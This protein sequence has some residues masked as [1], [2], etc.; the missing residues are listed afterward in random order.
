MKNVL[1]FV[2]LCSLLV[3][4]RGA[5]A[6]TFE[7][8]GQNA[9]AQK[10]QAK[11]GKA[12]KGK[13]VE[14]NA[15]S[16]GI[17]WGSS[18]EVGRMA[19]AAQDA[20]KHNN[21]VQAASFAERAANAAPQDA[22][23]WFLLGYTSRLAGRNQQSL[24]AY[25]RGLKIAPNSVDGLSGMAQTYAKMGQIDQAKRLLLQI[26][27][28]NPRRQNDLLM[29]GE[30][31]L[32][33][34]DTQQGITL[35]QRAEAIK[36]TSH[37]ELM[38]AVA[39]LK[40]KQPAKAK[41]L[42]DLAKRRDPKNPA[43]FRAV[44][45]YYREEHDYKNAIAI[46][47]SAPNPSPEI[48]ADLGYTYGLNGD[49][50]ESADAYIRAANAE[51]KQIGYQLSASQALMT[52]GQMD[53]SRQFI[54]RAEAIDANNYRLHAIKAGL[55]KIE[56]RPQDAI[57]EYTEAI[58]RLPQG[59]V[60]EGDLY[61]IQLRLNL[62]DLYREQGDE[63]ASRQQINVAEQMVNKLN[64]QGPA[65][66]EF[67][68]VRAGIF[69]AEQNYTAAEADLKEAL[70]L[71]PNNDNISLQ[72][73]NLLWRTKRPAEARKI[74]DTIL[75]KDKNNRFALEALGY[76]ARETGDN[77][78]AEAFFQ[79]LAKAYPNDYVAYLALGDLYTSTREFPR[80]NASYESAFTI[81]PTNP[82]IIANAANAAIEARQIDL[83][84]AWV[85]RAQGKLKDDPRIMRED[86]RYLFH[87][88]KFLESAQLGYKVLQQLPK[89]R[90]A[91]VYLV[92]ALYNLGRYDDVLSVAEKYE[93]ILEREPNFPLLVGHVHKQVNLLDQAV[94]DYS[95][96]IARDPKMAE[97][98]VNR[99]YVENDLQD[100][101]ASTSDFQQ[102]LTL[103]P[104]NGIAHLGMSFAN[105]QLRHGKQAL[106][107]ADAAE[108]LM[109]ESGATHLA[110][111]TAYRQMRL[112]DKAE[113]E[114]ETALKYAPDDLKLN[115][116]LADTQ[117]HA[118]HYPQALQTLD[119]ALRLSPDDPLIYAQ[120]AHAHAAMHD[121]EKT[122]QYV[123]A[124]ERAGNSEAAILLDTGDALLML[125][126]RQ[127]AMERFARALQAPDADK[128]ATRLMIAKVFVREGKFD[129]AKQQVAL[130]LAESRVGEA[131][132]VTADNLIEAANIFLAM[133]DYDL[134][135]GYF[136]RAKNAGAA[137]EVVAIGM[138]NAY[139]A[140]GK[141]DEAQAQ[142]ASLGN[143][144]DF[145]KNYDYMLA[146]GTFYH[147]RHDTRRAL[148][149]FARAYQVAGDD[150]IAEKQMEEVATEEGMPITRKVSVGSD[151]QMDGIFEDQTIYNI[152]RQLFGVTNS[153]QLPPP[154]SS[155]ET[156]WLNYFRVHQQGWPPISGFFQVRNARGQFSVPSDALIVNRDTYDYSLN[157][158]LN[159]S[160]RMGPVA[161]QF[162][163]GLQYT[164]R[165]DRLDPRDL[166]QNL[167]R[168]FV[169]MSSNSIGNW[170][171][172]HG[173]AFHETGPF[174]NKPYTSREVGA[175]VDFIVGRP[176]GRTQLLTGYT[177]RDLQ[178]NPIIRE[179]FSTTTSIGVQHQFGQSLKVAVLGDY[180]RS[181]RA[182]DFKYYLAQAM[183]PAGEIHWDINNRW[184]VE[185]NFIFSRGMGFHDYDNVQNSFLINY[186]R[187][188]RRSADDEGGEVSVAYPLRFSFGIQSA[189]YFNFTGT[190]QTNQI[191]PVIRLS[192]F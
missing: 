4:S 47:K 96:A 69:S 21:P 5:S 171:T 118:H 139:L 24:T 156:R 65:R 59:G 166:D 162:N 41:Q 179:F 98:Y 1:V 35:L 56:N 12:R 42:L 114:Y 122:L 78:T 46:L 43:I 155:L 190:G 6:Q 37:A 61:P 189:S 129:D 33:T 52:Q 149:T 169:Y 108:K 13:A 142:L 148:Y 115:M 173:A 106:D 71:D 25:Q 86:E 73:A 70:K 16:Q 147:Q 29:A 3:V 141:A 143:P 157:G 67:L 11:P 152:D 22:K 48:L 133:N 180:V 57:R 103:A 39:Y 112:L 36:P 138:A 76:L 158:A 165:R 90:N 85:A 62:A 192:L 107:E 144:A 38:M 161:F 74:Y 27:H 77:K 30:L 44:A 81:A 104:N 184:N 34:G 101:R 177:V 127:G 167:F 15:P 8:Q 191:R 150:P 170:L 116:A 128:V 7:I 117:Y 124:A 131:A 160:L 75:A 64:L 9:P 135:R 92:Y 87:K 89:D 10:N 121:R 72:Y 109:G 125:G 93:G 31:F 126:D 134:A 172:V 84:G 185:G 164:W 82:V 2:A 182:Q 163:A 183:R 28:E 174:L 137:D 151:F 18:I 91:S 19:R 88:G 102:A 68:R 132:P 123:Q 14:S 140:Q 111:A 120:M 153:Q 50:K 40:M 54:T 95:R 23:L 130:G 105:L 63:A 181:W 53:K 60:P 168:Q 79:R 55:A 97:A 17:G 176:W 113:K 186:V 51:P 32:T 26:V 136:E 188:F 175:T 45:N 110:R 145:A 94:N 187:P 100:P 83:A 119:Q 58:A 99:G 66:A 154:R 20:L 80:A 146:M 159:P 178:F 49:K